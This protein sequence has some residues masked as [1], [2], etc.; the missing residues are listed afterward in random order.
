[1]ANTATKC[2]RGISKNLPW[3][4]TLRNRVYA[5]LK[6][7]GGVC[8]CKNRRWQPIYDEACQRG[9]SQGMMVTSIFVSKENLQNL[10][11][12]NYSLNQF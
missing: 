8:R 11:N 5:T 2:Q 9:R 6:T 4:L 1:M 12:D 10:M 7:Q 3:A